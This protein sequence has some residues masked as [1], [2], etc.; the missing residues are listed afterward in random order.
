MRIF[1]VL[2]LTICS[3]IYA[4]TFN[5]VIKFNEEGGATVSISYSIERHF[6]FLLQT[7][8]E[9]GKYNTPLFFDPEKVRESLNKNG[10]RLKNL[11]IKNENFNK[12]I[13]FEVD[14]DDFVRDCKKIFKSSSFKNNFGRFIYHLKIPFLSDSI[15]PKEKEIAYK[16]F[17]NSIATLKLIAPNKIRKTNL[18]RNN[19]NSASIAIN[20]KDILGNKQRS[21][22][23]EFD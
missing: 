15:S 5:Q 12:R 22:F 7:L 6:L 14:F 3:S 1:F 13:E 21:L 20:I 10:A 19:K 17:S 4:I 9:P 18:N 16:I 11:S 8:K 2:F 23:F